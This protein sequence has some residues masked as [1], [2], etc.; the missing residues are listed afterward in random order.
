MEYKKNQNLYVE[1]IVIGNFIEQKISSK[2]S[3]KLA[4]PYFH[5]LV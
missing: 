4:F 3:V 1:N 2:K 5:K